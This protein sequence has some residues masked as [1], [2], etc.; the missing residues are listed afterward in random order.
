MAERKNHFPSHH[1]LFAHASKL[2]KYLQCTSTIYSSMHK[3]LI[4]SLSFP[5]LT[6]PFRNNWSPKKR[7]NVSS[8]LDDQKVKLFCTKNQ[9][10][11]SIASRFDG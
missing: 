5:F 3:V 4:E 9:S 8:L 6:L 7:L 2:N 1:L 10:S 11:R